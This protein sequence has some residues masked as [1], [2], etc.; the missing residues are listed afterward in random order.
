MV[1]VTTPVVELMLAEGLPA[2]GAALLGAMV[3]VTAT[4]LVPP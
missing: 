3:A 4:A 1:P 2:T